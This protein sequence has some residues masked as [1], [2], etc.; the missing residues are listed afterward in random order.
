MDKFN[1][2]CAKYPDQKRPQI[3]CLRHTYVASSEDDAMQ[4][5]RELSVFFNHFAAWFRNDRPIDDGLIAEMSAAEMEAFPAVLGRGPA[6]EP[7]RG[8]TRRGDRP[9]EVLRSHGL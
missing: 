6:Q 9:G 1:A 4:G 8:P 5:A 7:Y 3:M 2:A